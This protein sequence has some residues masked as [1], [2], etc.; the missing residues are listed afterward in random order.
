MTGSGEKSNP[1]RVWGWV[2]TL[3]GGVGLVASVFFFV[4]GILEGLSPGDPLS[5]AIGGALRAWGA[6]GALF[7]GAIALAAGSLLRRRAR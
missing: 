1:S 5:E 3:F 4:V 6:L 2:V 7:F